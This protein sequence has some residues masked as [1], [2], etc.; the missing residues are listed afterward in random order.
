[1]TRLVS[2]MVF[3]IDSLTCCTTISR[4]LYDSDGDSL[5]SLQSSSS[6]ASDVDYEGWSPYTSSSEE[7]RPRRFTRKEG[8]KFRPRSD[9]RSKKGPESSGAV[10]G[11][12]SP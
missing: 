3:L 11:V 7:D 9:R 1:M 6:D 12:G 4:R 5:P 8:S 10:P 2:F